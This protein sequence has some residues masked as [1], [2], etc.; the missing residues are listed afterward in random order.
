MQKQTI[1]IR[2]NLTIKSREFIQDPNGDKI[3]N[4]MHGF[5]GPWKTIKVKNRLTDA[6]RDFLLN[7]G[8]G[9]SLG[10]NGANYIAVSTD[11][12]SP[13]DSDTSL[14]GEISSGGL[15]RARGAVSHTDGTNTITISK[16]FTATAVHSSVQKA[17]I[18]TASSAG[19]MAHEATF[20]T[21]NL[22]VNDQLLIEWRMILDD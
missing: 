20:D 17:G 7:Q 2:E 13:A 16:T 3:I 18:F 5:Y 1:G 9:T 14:T 12:G 6:G 8:Y 10:T 22:K 4:G 15:S 21:L 19:T 11:G